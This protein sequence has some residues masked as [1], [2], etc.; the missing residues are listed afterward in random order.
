[1]VHLDLVTNSTL[2]RATK[3]PGAGKI[4]TLS[5]APGGGRRL[6]IIDPEGFPVNLVYGQYLVSSEQISTPEKLVYNF[7]D[8]K[9]RKNQFQRFTEGPTAVHKV[10]RLPSHS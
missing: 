7:G 4:E 1:L 8:E 3:I 10:I 2:Y 6:T 9:K 5:D